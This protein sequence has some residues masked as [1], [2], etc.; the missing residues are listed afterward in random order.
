MKTNGLLIQLFPFLLRHLP[1]KNARFR[2]CCTVGIPG[3]LQFPLGI[4]QY[5]HNQL[6]GSV[7]DIQLHIHCHSFLRITSQL[8]THS[9]CHMENVNIHTPTQRTDFLL[10][11]FIII[12][13][14][15][16]FIFPYKA[17]YILQKSN[18]LIIRLQ[19]LH[20]T[21]FIRF[22]GHHTVL[23]HG[24]RNIGIFTVYNSCC[25]RCGSKR[26]DHQHSQ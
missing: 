9:L 6:T 17:V 1:A 13:G 5:Y 12:T 4:A 16:I 15:T 26:H 22:N 11:L 10:S 23:G 18:R 24:S 2:N 25:K 20:F 7:F 8:K 3:I 14:R 19:C 21:Q